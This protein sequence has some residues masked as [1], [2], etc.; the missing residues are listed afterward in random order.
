M[1]VCFARYGRPGLVIWT[2]QSLSPRAA[3]VVSRILASPGP[4]LCVQVSSGRGK[5]LTRGG[6]GRGPYRVT[7][8]EACRVDLKSSTLVLITGVL[9][10]NTIYVH[11]SFVEYVSN[12]IAMICHL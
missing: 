2:W 11:Y 4:E 12:I 3:S 10:N 6:G 8:T 9:G 5:H 7:G 1:L